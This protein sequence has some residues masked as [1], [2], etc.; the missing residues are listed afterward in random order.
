MREAGLGRGNP[1]GSSRAGVA[2]QSCPKLGQEAKIFIHVV[3]SLGASCHHGG[4][5]T[6]GEVATFVPRQSLGG[7][8]EGHTMSQSNQQLRF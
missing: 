5:I 1:T 6:W 8:T 7:D 4:G 2:L 3:Q